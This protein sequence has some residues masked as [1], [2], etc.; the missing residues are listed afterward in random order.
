[1]SM[2][3]LSYVWLTAFVVVLLACNG[4][5]KKN[6]SGVVTDDLLCDTTE[7]GM[8]KY[9]SDDGRVAIY[10]NSIQDTL[11]EDSQI[12]CEIRYLDEA[13]KVHVVSGEI[14]TLVDTISSRPADGYLNGALE[15][16]YTFHVGGNFSVYVVE[17]SEY[18]AYHFANHELLAFCVKNGKLE[19]YPLFKSTENG[20]TT[21]YNTDG[22]TIETEGFPESMGMS[23]FTYKKEK[24][25]LVFVPY[26]EQPKY[27]VSFLF[28]GT[29]LE[30]RLFEE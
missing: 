27:Y 8:I 2:N 14:R 19:P 29:H 26:A 13:D 6:S 28:D 3:K 25:E 22:M 23:S 17:I 30:K 16:L 15:A 24:K 9:K 1:M 4:N 5:T 10:D 20:N 18:F 21:F 11:N 7:D 12:Y